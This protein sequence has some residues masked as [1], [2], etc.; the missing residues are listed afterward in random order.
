MDVNSVQ[1]ARTQVESWVLLRAWNVL[2]VR[3]SE[4]QEQYTRSRADLVQKATMQEKEAS[5]ACLVLRAH[6]RM[7]REKVNVLSVQRVP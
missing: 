5:S 3:S 1:R 6:I 4:G 7:N 2:A